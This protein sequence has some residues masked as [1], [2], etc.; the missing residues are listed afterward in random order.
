MKGQAP[1]ERVDPVAKG[2]AQTGLWL[3]RP[4]RRNRHQRSIALGH[5]FHQLIEHAA[6]AA[7][8]LLAVLQ[9][10]ERR[11]LRMRRLVG[12]AA[13]RQPQPPLA[14]AHVARNIR[15]QGRQQRRIEGR[16]LPGERLVLAEHRAQREH[17][18]LQRLQA[19][20]QRPD[21]GDGEVVLLTWRILD[22]GNRRQGLIQTTT[23][24]DATDERRQVQHEQHPQSREQ[25]TAQTDDPD[26]VAR[27][28]A[29]RR[30]E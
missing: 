13:R 12:A 21:P 10:F 3:H 30:R 11:C 7:G 2:R 25:Q 22:L 19:S 5:T 28:R 8:C 18:R 15:H 4:A 16:Q 27:Q 29:T 1:V 26:G 17:I 6:Q 24:P 9:V 14:A 20:D 23:N